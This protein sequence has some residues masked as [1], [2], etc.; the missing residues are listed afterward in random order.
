[1]ETGKEDYTPSTRPWRTLVY[2]ETILDRKNV[3][4]SIPGW[5]SHVPVIIKIDTLPEDIQSAIKRG[6]K[7][8]Y[9]HVN[10]G[11]EMAMQLKFDNWELPLSDENNDG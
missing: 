11:A 1:M 3:R 5:N 10:I 2:I 6:T 9:A 7:R 8:L 4:V